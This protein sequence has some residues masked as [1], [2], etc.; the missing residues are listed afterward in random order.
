MNRLGI[1]AAAVSIFVVLFGLTACSDA[2]T[3]TGNS[4]TLDGSAASGAPTITGNW[5]TSDGSATKTI[6]DDNSCSGM[7]YNAGKVLDIGGPETCTLSSGSQDGMYSL[8]VR[9]PPNQETLGV[10]FSGNTMT[11]YSSGQKIVTLTKQ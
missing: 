10:K 5:S 3:I 9:Q 6:S 2:P 4:S 8:V 7:Y 11:L 1:S